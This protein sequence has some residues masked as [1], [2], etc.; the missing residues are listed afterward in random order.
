MLKTLISLV[1][2]FS[3]CMEKY[4][5]SGFAFVLLLTYDSELTGEE[6]RRCDQEVEDG[7]CQHA[8]S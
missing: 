8:G 5:G 3:H 7:A 2:Q 6:E 4:L 1:K